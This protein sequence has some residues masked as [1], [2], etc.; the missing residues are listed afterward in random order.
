[1]AIKFTIK[2]GRY[3]FKVGARWQ[4]SYEWVMRRKRSFPTP[5]R[6]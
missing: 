5:K 6:E 4:F 1:M 3:E 2:L